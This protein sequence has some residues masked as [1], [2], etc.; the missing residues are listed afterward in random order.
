MT[1]LN[2]KPTFGAGRAFLT[3]NYQSH[4][5]RAFVPQSQ[6]IDFKRKTESLFGERQLVAV[7]AGEWR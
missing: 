7:G 1:V 3:G 5:A 6:S 4:P 2:G